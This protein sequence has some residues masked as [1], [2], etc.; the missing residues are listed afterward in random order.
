MDEASQALFAMIASCKNLG[1]KVIWI[2]DQKQLPPVVSLSEEI[3][4]RND[5]SSLVK[6]FQTLCD[7]FDFPSFVLTDT[8]RLQPQAAKLTSVFYDV[9]LV[10]V[11]SNEL[12]KTGLPFLDKRGGTSIVEIEM[13]NGEKADRNSCNQLIDIVA[14][15]LLEMPKASIAVLSKFRPTVRMLQNCFISRFGYKNNVLIDTVER[16][17]GIT[18]DICFYFIP[19]VMFSLSLNK[20]LFNVV[21]SRAK[22]YTVLV[23]DKSLLRQNM[24]IE[25]RRYLLKAQED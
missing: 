25:V 21:T 1:N 20:E 7:Q 19:N 16:V 9:P 11:S 18:C 4:I 5:Y 17:Q 15:L 23:S 6:G 24:P 13:P 3:I 10:S 8:F 2:G 14:Q 12:S 22:Q